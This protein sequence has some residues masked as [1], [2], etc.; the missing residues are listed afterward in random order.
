MHFLEA[1]VWRRVDAHAQG[2]SAAHLEM[3]KGR[4]G[5]WGSANRRDGPARKDDG[6]CD[7]RVRVT[8]TPDAGGEET[9]E[10]HL[11]EQK[12]LLL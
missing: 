8:R 1:T 6:D 12:A 7:G 9:H 4:A 5:T 11:Q 3:Q 10:P 2:S